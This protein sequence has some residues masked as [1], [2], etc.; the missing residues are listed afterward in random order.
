MGPTSSPSFLDQ[1]VLHLAAEL[2][3]TDEVVRCISPRDYWKGENPES[4]GR[5]DVNSGGDRARKR[6]R[7]D[8]CAASLPESSSASGLL[9]EAPRMYWRTPLFNVRNDDG[10]SGFDSDCEEALLVDLSVDLVRATAS[11]VPNHSSSLSTTDSLARE[12]RADIRL[13]ILIRQRGGGAE[14]VRSSP[15]TFGDLNAYAKSIGIVLDLKEGARPLAK[16]LA[17]ALKLLGQRSSC[18]TSPASVSGNGN[19]ETRKMKVDLYHPDLFEYGVLALT[20]DVSVS[21]SGE[22]RIGS[23]A[24]QMILSILQREDAERAGRER[25]KEAENRRGVVSDL[26]DNPYNRKR[27]EERASEEREGKERLEAAFQ[28]WWLCAAGECSGNDDKNERDT[29][30]PATAAHL[31]TET[32]TATGSDCA[33]GGG[34]QLAGEGNAETSVGEGNRREDT[35]RDRNRAETQ[36][37]VPSPKSSPF[38][39]THDVHS[40]AT[41][42]LSTS[43]G[44]TSSRKAKMKKP[45]ST[46]YVQQRG[47][48]FNTST[49][50][51]KKRGAMSFGRMN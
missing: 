1:F 50:G 32:L 30:N 7:S 10:A 33:A 9:G 6:P 43:E 31:R 22:G 44:S 25:R 48:R 39:Q 27:N 17:G 47:G 35:E 12:P 19:A 15:L 21:S 24:M 20:S 28:A 41:V 11:T 42:D 26:P 18:Q 4:G 29:E 36:P 37:M 14:Y 45:S 40:Q 2:V 38:K 13:G 3:G 5:G 46:V 51:K 16:V 8:I 49:G 34:S 23:L